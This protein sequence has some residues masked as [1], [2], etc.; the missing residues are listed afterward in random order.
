M[1]LCSLPHSDNPMGRLTILFKID[2]SHVLYILVIYLLLPRLTHSVK[3]C[4]TAKT[5]LNLIMEVKNELNAFENTI[6]TSTYKHNLSHDN[7]SKC[8]LICKVM[9]PTAGRQ[10][11]HTWRCVIAW[12]GLRAMKRAFLWNINI[13]VSCF[14]TNIMII[15]NISLIFRII[16]FRCPSRA[17]W[18]IKRIKLFKLY[19]W[20]NEIIHN[21]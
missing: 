8:C 15:L 16:S 11:S 12:A 20:Y 17:Y 21:L 5:S 7:S 14:M 3:K 4:V 1:R 6:K 2:I 10:Q 18:K 13:V 19:N 9:F